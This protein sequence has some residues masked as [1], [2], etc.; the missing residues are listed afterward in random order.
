[1]KN[2]HETI[3]ELMKIK[4]QLPVEVDINTNMIFFTNDDN[5][6][7]ERKSYSDENIHYVPTNTLV[8]ST[9]NKNKTISKQ[10]KM[11]TK[12]MKRKANK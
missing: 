9:S 12:T 5:K 11:S 7:I 1:M 2:P 4:G 6:H 3:T 8:Q 10:K